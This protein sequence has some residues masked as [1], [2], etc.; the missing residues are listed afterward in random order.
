MAHHH[1]HH[2]VGDD[3]EDGDGDDGATCDG[4]GLEEISKVVYNMLFQHVISQQI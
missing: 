4:D 3:D 2:Q 1:P